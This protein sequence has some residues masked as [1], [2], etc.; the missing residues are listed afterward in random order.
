MI[1]RS[2][3]WSEYALDQVLLRQLRAARQHQVGEGAAILI[4]P[5]ATILKSSGPCKLYGDIDR[6]AGAPPRQGFQLQFG[7]HA[8]EL[9]LLPAI[10]AAPQ[11][12]NVKTRIQ[13]MTALV[14]KRMPAAI[15]SN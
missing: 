8:S 1:H 14:Q 12:L 7:G 15:K 4:Q 11:A 2:I 13:S 10:G 6:L 5:R 9:A 3:S